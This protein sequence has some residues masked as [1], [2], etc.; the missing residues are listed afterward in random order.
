MG[1]FLHILDRFII[2][3]FSSAAVLMLA[4]VLF[5]YLERAWSKFPSWLLRGWFF[6]LVPGV[7]AFLLIASREIYDVATGNPPIKSYFDYLSWVLGIGLA[8]WGRLRIC[9]RTLKAVEEIK[10]GRE[11]DRSD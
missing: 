1:T 10:E 3:L 4:Q 7:F 6:F 11:N 9:R 2:H 5:V 8:T